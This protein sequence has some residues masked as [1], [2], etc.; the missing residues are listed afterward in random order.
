MSNSECNLIYFDCECK[1]ARA[2]NRK[3]NAFFFQYCF[4]II[5]IIS[6][7]FLLSRPHAKPHIFFCCCCR[8]C[9]CFF[10]FLF[11]FLLMYRCRILLAVLLKCRN[12][13]EHNCGQSGL[14][15]HHQPID[16][17]QSER[18][19]WKSSS[20]AYWDQLC[21]VGCQCGGTKL[22]ESICIIIPFR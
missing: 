20:I 15:A 14:V 17:A 1:S 3:R 2:R 22:I 10:F 18:E 6:I 16:H 19:K 21:I 11:A 12:Q 9:C 7:Q 5:M 13:N 8:C 4:H